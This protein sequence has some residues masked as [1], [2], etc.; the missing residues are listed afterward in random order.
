METTSEIINQINKKLTEA[1]VPDHNEP[2]YCNSVIDSTIF[3]KSIKNIDNNEE[4]F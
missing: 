1:L 2:I 4:T 3:N